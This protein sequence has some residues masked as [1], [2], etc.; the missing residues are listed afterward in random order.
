MFNKNVGKLCISKSIKNMISV[1]SRE[2]IKQR[3]CLLLCTRPCA[4][5]QVLSLSHSFCLKLKPKVQLVVALL[6][7]PAIIDAVVRF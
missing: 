1:Y 7:K 2:S 3:T 6:I 4:I 5:F